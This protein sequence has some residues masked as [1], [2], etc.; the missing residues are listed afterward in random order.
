MRDAYNTVFAESEVNGKKVVVLQD[1]DPSDPRE[2]DTLGVMACFHKRYTLGDS[3]EY[4]KDDYGSWEEFRHQLVLDGAVNLRPL[5][6]YDHSGISISIGSFIGR[7]QHAE[8]DSGQV[9]YIYTT[10]KALRDNGLTLEDADRIL[11]GE[12]ETYDSYLTGQ[13]YGYIVETQSTCE[14][15]SHTETHNEDSCWGFYSVEEALAEGMAVAS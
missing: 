8:W 5:Y 6:L 14:S 4:I 10:E 3:H 7:A 2:W 12:V 13:V 1:I 11:E 9:G 15:C